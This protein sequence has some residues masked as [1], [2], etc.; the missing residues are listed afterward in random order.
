MRHD[1]HSPAPAL[2]HVDPGF[3]PVR[4]AFDRVMAAQPGG[5]GLAVYADGREVVHLWGGT[6][7]RTGAAFTDDSL[8]L[9][10]SCSKGVTS[11]C[12]NMLAE[13]GLLDLDAPVAE[14]WP[15]FAAA[16]KGAVPVRWLLTHRTGLALFSPKDHVRAEDLLDWDTICSTLAAQEPLWE[17]GTH[18][19]Y[20]SLTFG[21]LVGEV[22]RRVSGRT[23]G[24][25]L[26][27]HVTGPLGAEYWFGLP[28][29]H[30]HRMLPNVRPEDAPQGITDLAGL[31]RERGL[32]TTTPLARAMLH[33]PADGPDTAPWNSR[34]FHAAEI[35]ATNGIG[36]ARGLARIFAA[37]IGEVDGVRLLSDSTV[38]SARLPLTDDVPTPPELRAIT[39][40]PPRFG[41]GFQLPR[42]SMDAM[43][44]PGSFGHTG[45][46]G[47][48]AFAHPEKGIAFGFTCDT[49]LWDG[50]AGPDPRW[51]P[52]LSA[53]EEVIGR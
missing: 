31:Y 1:P 26:A 4:D 52:L 23:V 12:A 34:A 51:T 53:L 9:T 17:P 49:L 20:H 27:E 37:C 21:Y 36:T 5:A 8:V 3:E 2:G 11:V 41:T 22:I 50:L 29:E 14:Y 13:R 18:C 19:G 10:A 45:A 35:P 42:P 16:G 44:G 43:L 46:G 30:E 15:E 7:P 28:E 25:F 47:R 33:R 39:S 32:D 48:L 38:G 24:Q 40:N 6:N